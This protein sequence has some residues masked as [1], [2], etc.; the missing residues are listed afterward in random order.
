LILQ[1][2][3]RFQPATNKVW[4]ALVGGLEFVAEDQEILCSR[5]LLLTLAASS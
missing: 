3:Q 4:S 5:L 1:N 2:T